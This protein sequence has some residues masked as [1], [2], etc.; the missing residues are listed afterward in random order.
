MPNSWPQADGRTAAPKVVGLG[1][2]GM[3]YLAAVD[4]FPAPDEKMRTQELEV[5]WHWCISQ[6]NCVAGLLRRP[7]ERA[8]VVHARLIVDPDL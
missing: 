7:R 6:C 1:S 2:L 8:D 5:G 3:D 4:H